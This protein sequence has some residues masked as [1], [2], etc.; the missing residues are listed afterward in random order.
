MAEYL[1]A[2]DLGTSG[3]KATLFRTDGELVKSV[4][5]QYPT[6]FFNSTWAEQDPEDW[7]RAVCSN[8]RELLKDLGGARVAG[9]AFSG[10]MMGCVVVDRQGKALRNAII[11]AD[12]RSQ[13]QEA[14]IRKK[15]DEQEFY[16]ITG[17]RISA[18]YSIEKLMWIRDNEPEIFRNIYKM[19]QPKDYIV[20]KLTGKYVTDFSDA[21][22]TNCLD[23]KKLE[24]SDLLL[25]MMKIDRSLLPEP[26]PSTY[27]AGEITQGISRECGLPVGTPVILGGGDGLCAAVGAGSVKK[28]ITY[29]YLGTSSWVAFTSDT[30]VFDREMRTYNWA[31]MV[32]G[33]YTPNGTMQA[34]GNS[35]HFVKETICKDLDIAAAAQKISPYELMNQEI[36]KSSLGANG[37]LYL[38]YIL[39]ERSPRWNSEAKGA[40]IGLKMEHTRGDMLRACIE[41]IVMNL[42][43]IL[44]IFR[45]EHPIDQISI[46][47]GLA[48][49]KV[50]RQIL[51]DIYGLPVCRLNYLDEA[52][53]MGAAVAAGGI[54]T[55]K[56]VL[57]MIQAGAS[58]IGTSAGVKI[59]DDYR[60]GI[61]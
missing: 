10:Q 45:A 57:E 12:Q 3:D 14:A 56:D 24:W 6:Y 51:A 20:A 29:N 17:H 19:L 33:L 38:P 40:Y 32:P 52:T 53:S 31:H 58:R 42:N 27:A 5:Y 61:A 54:R 21:S 28:G 37:L 30:P 26:K 36:E 7:W 13:E 59:V 60:N 8:N 1:L 22:G 55:A 34:A 41:G 2:H 39:G 49:G 9:M 23:L 43:I 44:Q 16:Q 50:I 11:W 25:E 48:K 18:S 35:Y 4:T 46:I 15:V 47:G